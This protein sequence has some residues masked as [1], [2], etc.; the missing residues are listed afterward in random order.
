MVG[1]TLRTIETR[2]SRHVGRHPS[3]RRDEIRESLAESAEHP[4][5]TPY[6]E[7]VRFHS[8]G[9][10]HFA[11]HPG[12]QPRRLP[13]AEGVSQGGELVTCRSWPFVKPLRGI[14]QN[15][16]RSPRVPRKAR[17]PWAAEYNRFAVKRLAGNA[18]WLTNG[19][20]VAT[21][22]RIVFPSHSPP[23]MEAVK[24]VA[25]KDKASAGSCQGD[26]VHHARSKSSPADQPVVCMRKQMTVAVS[27]CCHGVWGVIQWLN[28]GNRQT[29]AECL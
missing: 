5:H 6:A 16:H 24:R 11:A 4:R 3:G 23:H 17:R 1:R 8:P 20:N 13:Y 15:T 26:R 2:C 29:A 19:T 25:V 10:P 21:T 18:N 7:G 12:L 14:C 9:S 27:Q 28:T 22:T